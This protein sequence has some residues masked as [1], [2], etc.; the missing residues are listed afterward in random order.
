MIAILRPIETYCEYLNC[1]PK[2]VCSSA[3]T[4]KKSSDAE[5]FHMNI[6]KVA[7]QS[8]LHATEH[9]LQDVALADQSFNASSEPFSQATEQ[10]QSDY[11]EIFVRSFELLLIL[12]VSL[13]DRSNVD[14]S[15]AVKEK[16]GEHSDY[17]LTHESLPQYTQA[18]EDCTTVCRITDMFLPLRPLGTSPTYWDS[19]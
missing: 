4:Q 9:Q 16:Q 3:S 12:H 1:A 6:K 11:H 10:V 7:L 19:W 13:P 8:H 17:C 15:H 18:P 5:L 14:E 2:A